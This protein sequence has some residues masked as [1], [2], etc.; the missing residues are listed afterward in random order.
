MVQFK[1]ILPSALLAFS[2]LGAPLAMAEP[3]QAPAHHGQMQK[4]SEEDR[5]E[6]H[7]GHLHDALKVTAQQEEQW[8]PVAQTMR[9]NEKSLRELAK[10]KRGKI[11]TQTAVEDLAAYAEI[12]EAHA[13]SIKKLADVFGTFYAGLGD[14][15]KK[16]ADEFFR[17]HKHH[18]EKQHGPEG[19][20]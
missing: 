17:D 12:A 15:Q 18:S 6:R 5:L 1:R 13:Q 3:A 19:H 11:E 2:V 7:I 9:D 4:M 14:E 8:K 20:H 10:A 16:V